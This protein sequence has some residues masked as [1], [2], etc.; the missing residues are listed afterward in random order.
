MEGL[1]GALIEAMAL[2]TPVVA[3][4]LGGI[5]E[6]V[7]DEGFT[8]LVAPESPAHLAAG[9]TTA[10]A[11]EPGSRQRARAARQHF[12]Q[13]FSIGQV[14]QRMKGLYDKVLAS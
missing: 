1:P 13:H 2:Q 11:D 14:A 9:I 10:L 5:R 12:V 7:P 3:S 4:D 6:V 8:R